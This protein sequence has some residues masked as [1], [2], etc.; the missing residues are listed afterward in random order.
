MRDALLAQARDTLRAFGRAHGFLRP[1]LCGCGRDTCRN[2]R[3]ETMSLV[4]M[5]RAVASG[6]RGAPDPAGEG[7]LR[8]RLLGFAAVFGLD[9]CPEGNPD[10][11]CA[12]LEE[13]STRG[14]VR[15]V[16]DLW[17]GRAGNRVAVTSAWISALAEGHARN[18]AALDV[19]ARHV[20]P[21]RDEALR[22]VLDQARAAEGGAWLTEARAMA[23]EAVATWLPAPGTLNEPGR[24]TDAA[25]AVAY[26]RGWTVEEAAELE[27]VAADAS[28]ALL[29]RGIV[30]PSVTEVLYAPMA[31]AVRAEDLYAA[32]EA[33]EIVEGPAGNWS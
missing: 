2:A 1:H 13:E 14:V 10:C 31:H 23:A 16:A 30:H 29:T 21:D 5:L 6:W 4:A 3:E 32:A 33:L 22:A 9:A 8:I 20:A 27:R 18:L 7:L 26:H 28:S 25:L 12:R 19:L 15:A 24:V 11:A 17:H